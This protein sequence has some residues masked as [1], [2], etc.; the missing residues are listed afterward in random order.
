VADEFAAA[1]T[2]DLKKPKRLCV[3]V[4]K[5][6]E[7]VPDPEAVLL[8][9]KAKPA[10]GQPKH[11]KRK[12]VYVGHQFATGQLDTVGEQELCVPSS[13]RLPGPA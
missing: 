7:G 6:G 3:A 8:C 10:K 11:E 12:G 13:I 5:N 1:R 4:D 2:L 9:Y